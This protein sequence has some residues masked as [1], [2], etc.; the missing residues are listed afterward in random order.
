MSMPG[1]GVCHHFAWHLMPDLPGVIDDDAEV[2]DVLK[3]VNLLSRFKLKFKF[4]DL[5]LLYTLVASGVFFFCSLW[6]AWH[7]APRS[8]A[9][10]DLIEWQ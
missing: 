5:L 10:R 9:L 6:V 8:R 2:Q 1:R 3:I 7:G 4:K